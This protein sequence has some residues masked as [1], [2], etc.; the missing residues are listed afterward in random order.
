M[1]LAQG[2]P[3]SWGYDQAGHWHESIA[4][5]MPIRDEGVADEENASTVRDTLWGLL[6]SVIFFWLPIGAAVVLWWRR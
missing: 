4:E 3:Q 1:E 6:I 5:V 2:I